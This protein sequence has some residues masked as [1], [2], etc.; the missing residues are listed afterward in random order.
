M[1]KAL[2]HFTTDKASIEECYIYRSGEL[3]G[4]TPKYLRIRSEYYEF[5]PSDGSGG[6]ERVMIHCII[7]TDIVQRVDVEIEWNSEES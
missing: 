1:V 6:D 2:D 3:L 4:E 7:K 5:L